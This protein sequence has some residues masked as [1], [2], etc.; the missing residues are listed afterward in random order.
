MAEFSPINEIKPDTLAQVI[1]DLDIEMTNGDELDLFDE[2]LQQALDSGLDSDPKLKATIDELLTDIAKAEEVPSEKPKPSPRSKK[3]FEEPPSPVPTDTMDTASSGNQTPSSARWTITN[4]RSLTLL[5][6]YI[7]VRLFTRQET[8]KKSNLIN[9]FTTFLIPFLPGC[10]KENATY[11]VMDTQAA[12]LIKRARIFQKIAPFYNIFIQRPTYTFSTSTG[13]Q[14]MVTES[15]VPRFFNKAIPDPAYTNTDILPLIMTVTV[16]IS[17]KYNLHEIRQ[18]MDEAQRR[19]TPTPPSPDVTFL[20]SQPVSSR[21]GPPVPRLFPA[22]PNDH[23]V[24]HIEESPLPTGSNPEKKCW[25][26]KGPSK[27]FKAKR[28]ITKKNKGVDPLQ[29]KKLFP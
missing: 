8:T 10:L 1:N 18:L 25:A 20:K 21:L 17:A 19:P 3:A 11:Y 4:P 22:S 15:I 12:T 9:F 14:F 27:S 23:P 29:P 7:E 16:D 28:R 26:P 2:D 6:S 24:I 13:A 5:P